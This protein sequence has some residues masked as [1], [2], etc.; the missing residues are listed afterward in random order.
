[1]SGL[2]TRVKICGVRTI[3]AIEAAA[4]AGADALGFVF[5]RSSPRFIEPGD[6]WPLV[7]S[8]PPMTTS[9]GLFQDVTLE[10]FIEVEQLCPTALTQLH[11]SEPPRLVRECG[12]GV[13]KSVRFEAGSIARTLKAWGEIDEVDAVLIDG[14]S[15]GKGTPF[16][17]NE[18]APHL[19]GYPKP[20]II[21]GGLTPENV[22]EAIR[23]LR[24]FAVDVSS[25]V[26]S[27]P[28]VKDPARI[29]AFCEAVRDANGA[30]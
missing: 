11:G 29:R 28:G 24:P 23:T 21:A 18:L 25:G 30:R 2:R 12:P 4:D 22:G 5:V 13:I 16:D 27:S 8:L 20:I 3:E 26:E 14:S 6:A 19:A 1:M 7:A 17:W 10:E 15:G 9:V